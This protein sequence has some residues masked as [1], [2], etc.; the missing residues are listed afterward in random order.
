MPLDE[1]LAETSKTIKSFEKQ[2]TALKKSPN[3]EVKDTSVL[4]E[5]SEW[6]KQHFNNSLRESGIASHFVHE[7]VPFIV[8]IYH[9]TDWRNHGLRKKQVRT[10][11]F[12]QDMVSH[13][14]LSHF[15]KVWWEYLLRYYHIFLSFQVR[16]IFFGPEWNK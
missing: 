3:K 1:D 16:N 10:Y 4:L 11:K 14:K 2:S 6:Q 9:L 12:V 8:H 13:Y 7:H 15:I 5:R